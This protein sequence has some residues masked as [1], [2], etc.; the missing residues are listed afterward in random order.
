MTKRLLHDPKIKS[1]NFRFE[2]NSFLFHSCVDNHKHS[3]SEAKRAMRLKVVRPHPLLIPLTSAPENIEK[4][5][6]R[7]TEVRSA[8]L[9]EV[10]LKKRKAPATSCGKLYLENDT[11]EIHIMWCR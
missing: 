7:P 5:P 8:P 10:F 4:P 3:E 9:S 6:T 11:L 2:K 1:K